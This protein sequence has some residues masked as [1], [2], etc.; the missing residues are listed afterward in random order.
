MLFWDKIYCTTIDGLALGRVSISERRQ[1]V[2]NKRQLDNISS[3]FVSY[4]SL[5]LSFFRSHLNY[6]VR[7]NGWMLHLCHPGPFFHYT[8]GIFIVQY[9]R[10]SRLNLRL[11]AL[12][13]P[14]RLLPRLCRLLL[15]GRELPPR[16]RLAIPAKRHVVRTNVLIQ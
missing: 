4:Q 11:Y 9:S 12:C 1:R 5:T 2:S 15:A 7:L 13:H 14:S 16:Y 3:I 8:G 6:S 10:K